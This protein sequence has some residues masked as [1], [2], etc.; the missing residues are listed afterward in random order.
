LPKI[1]EEL[2]RPGVGLVIHNMGLDTRDGSD[3]T[4]KL[5]VLAAIAAVRA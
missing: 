2:A 4:A 5:T 3:P 1:A